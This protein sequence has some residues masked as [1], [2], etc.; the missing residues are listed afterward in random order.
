M[1][2]TTPAKPVT[3]EDASP[4]PKQSPA[5]LKSTQELPEVADAAASTSA[6][7]D[8]DIAERKDSKEEDEEWDPSAESD[9][10]ATRTAAV[11]KGKEG[12]T[13]AA[14][15]TGDWQAIWAP[16]NNGE[17]LLSCLRLSFF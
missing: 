15:G 16:A 1:A 9:I 2:S 10:K 14:G 11:E 3:V 5:S 6:A 13:Q 7:K 8:V 4:S 12:D 17:N